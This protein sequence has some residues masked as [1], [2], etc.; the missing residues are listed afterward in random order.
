MTFEE[1][2]DG[3]ESFSLRSERAM[4]ET[5]ATDP[6]ALRKWLEE[7]FNQGKFSDCDSDYIRNEQGKIK[8]YMITIGNKNFRCD[9]GGNVFSK[10]KSTNQYKCNSCGTTY[11]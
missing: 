11:E 9:C 10:F 2:Y 5:G 7:A 1:W 6:K 8:N 4:S 3:V